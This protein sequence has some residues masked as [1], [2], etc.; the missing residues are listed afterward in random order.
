MT[1]LVRKQN[2]ARIGASVELAVNGYEQVGHYPSRWAKQQT[3]PS[4]QL[5]EV[6]HSEAPNS[7]KEYRVMHHAWRIPPLFRT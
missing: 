4:Q 3:N 7:H 1:D 5:G 6:T 2:D